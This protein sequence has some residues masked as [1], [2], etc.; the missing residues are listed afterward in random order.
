MLLQALYGVGGANC[1]IRLMGRAGD[2][3]LQHHRDAT[4]A[5]NC[6]IICMLF[7]MEVTLMGKDDVNLACQIVSIFDSWR[8]VILVLCSVHMLTTGRSA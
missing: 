2:A 4:Y 3:G 6:F 5:M 8:S 1:C 7:F